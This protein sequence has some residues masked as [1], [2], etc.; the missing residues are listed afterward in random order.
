LRSFIL[1]KAKPGKEHETQT[2]LKALPEVREIHLITGKFDFLITLESEETEL[3]PRQKI[4]ELVLQEIRRSGGVSDTRTIIP[5]NSQY[6]Q[7]TPTDRPTIKAF[8]FI[9]SEAGKE[10]ELVSRLLNLPEVS[11]VHLLFGKADLLAELDAE[12]SFIH[13]PPQHIASLVQTKIS[14]L[15]GV[16]DTDT[17]VPLESVL[18]N[19]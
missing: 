18:K 13:P 2:R 1:I 5:I 14:K 17:Y 9:Q 3:D 10:N 6:H 8:V 4:I 15:S 16:R 11:G 12:K 7:T 19:Q